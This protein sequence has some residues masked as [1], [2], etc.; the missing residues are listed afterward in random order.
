MHANRR[1]LLLAG[2]CAASTALF[3]SGAARLMAEGTDPP[4]ETNTVRLAKTPAICVAPQYVVSDLLNAEGFT[5]VV[6]VPSD[7]GVE[8][9]KAI[10]NDDIDLAL[11]FS[12]P[13]LLQIERGLSITVLAGIHVGCFELFAKDGIHSV[14]DL[15]GRTVGIQALETSPHVFL[16]AMATLV[17]LNPAKDIAWVTSGSVKPI[18]LFAEGK[19]DAFL[20]FPPE[21]Q[22][23]RAQNIGHV[24]VNSAQDR[25]WSQ[26][27]CCMLAGNREFVRKNPIATKRVVRA[28]LRATDLCVSEPALV[29]QRMVDRGFTPRRDYAVQTLADV[30]YNRWR[31]YDPED[32]IRFYALRLREAGMLKSSP[33][34]IVTDGVDWRFLNEVRGELGG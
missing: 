2:A 7:A 30:P 5:N 24:I 21:P 34:K 18:E 9:T 26:Y 25:P 33:A 23:L 31:D 12:G 17:G 32:T 19:I 6:Y 1:D 15:K 10:A 22:Q 14:A 3:W 8:Q 20:G 16:S 13:L 4:P 11:H 27:F 28:M 29:A